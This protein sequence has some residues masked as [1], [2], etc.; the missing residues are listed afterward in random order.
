[1]SIA[2]RESCSRSGNTGRATVCFL[3]AQIASLSVSRL[4]HYTHQGL[5]CCLLM[6]NVVS[7]ARANFFSFLKGKLAEAMGP[8]IY[9]HFDYTKHRGHLRF[10]LVFLF[11]MHNPLTLHVDRDWGPLYDEFTL[12]NAC[13]IMMENLISGTVGCARNVCSRDHVDVHNLV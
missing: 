2:R 3:I 9:V 11:L 5:F 7:I 10:L 13:C 1:M 12:L 8:P 6:W 4:A